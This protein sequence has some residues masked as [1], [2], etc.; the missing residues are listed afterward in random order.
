MFAGPPR[1]IS[2]AR[3]A[4]AMASK[5]AA[6]VKGIAAHAPTVIGDLVQ[7]GIAVRAPTATVAPRWMATVDRARTGIVV[8][9]R[10]VNEAASRSKTAVRKRRA[11]RRQSN[12]WTVIPA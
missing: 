10:V 5:S 11:V 4:R 8:R 2:A 7:M 3:T 1:Q 9:S 12:Q 6:P